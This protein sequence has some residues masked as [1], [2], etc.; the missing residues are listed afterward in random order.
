MELLVNGTP[1]TSISPTMLS[2]IS[3]LNEM[4]EVGELLYVQN[5]TATLAACQL[6]KGKKWGQLFSDG[7]SQQQ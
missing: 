3:I 5:L 4:V 2:C 7:T 6:A 1:P